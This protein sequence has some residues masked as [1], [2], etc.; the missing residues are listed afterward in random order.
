MGLFDQFKDSFEEFKKN[1][2]ATGPVP[3][4]NYVLK[5]D[6]VK[7]D[8]SSQPTRFSFIWVILRG[9]DDEE[10]GFAGRKIYAGYQLKEPSV[11]F[12]MQD[13]EKM[14]VNFDKYADAASLAGDLQDLA[15]TTAECYVKPREY[16]GKT[17]YNVYLNEWNTGDVLAGVNDKDEIPF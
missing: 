11:A 2:P 1:A 4:G 13:L 16:N 5:L 17:Y 9:I 8:M 6:E 14:G 12:F 3:E 10:S 15:G 7:C